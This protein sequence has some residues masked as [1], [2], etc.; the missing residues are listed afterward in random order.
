[1]VARSDDGEHLTTVAMLGRERFGAESL[2]RLCSRH[3][4]GLGRPR[5]AGRPPV[6]PD[7]SHEL[8]TE[9]IA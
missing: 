2:E 6:L 1:M 7:E 5:R 3:V 4:P 8:R 9:L